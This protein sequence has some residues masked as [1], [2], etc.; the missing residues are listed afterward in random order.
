MAA[1]S[2]REKSAGNSGQIKLGEPRW[3]R[4]NSDMRAED[5]SNLIRKAPFQPIRLHLSNGRT[6]DIRHP[7]MA[8][9]SRSLVAS[10]EPGEGDIA[11]HIVHFNLLHIVEIE[12]INGE[13]QS[14]GVA[15]ASQPEPG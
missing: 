7:E 2:G 4:Y 10:G 1:P 3:K 13:R 15:P 12:P 6:V 9:V 11:D 14:D 8:I 5:L